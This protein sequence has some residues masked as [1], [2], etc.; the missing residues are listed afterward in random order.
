MTLVGIPER[1]VGRQPYERAPASPS[2]VPIR[3]PK[4]ALIGCL[5]MP[6]MERRGHVVASPDRVGDA[7][8]SRRERSDA[9][10]SGFLEPWR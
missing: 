1:L 9:S 8:A 6:Y 7:L 2:L 4:R 3:R 5:P 10:P